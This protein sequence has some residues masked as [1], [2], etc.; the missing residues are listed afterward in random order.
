MM[1]GYRTDAVKTTEGATTLHQIPRFHLE[2]RALEVGILIDRAWTNERIADVLDAEFGARGSDTRTGRRSDG[3]VPDE[4]LY[5]AFRSMPVIWPASG[6]VI[7]QAEARDRVNVG[8]D[9]AIAAR[10][11]GATDGGEVSGGDGEPG[12]APTGGLG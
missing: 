7:S 10:V 8:I 4:A 2:I 5:F 1:K 3:S 9:R 12:S 11:R 6:E